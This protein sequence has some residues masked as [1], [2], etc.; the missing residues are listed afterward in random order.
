M[1]LPALLLA[2]AALAACGETRDVANQFEET[3]KE[4]ANTANSI[5]STADNAARAAESALDE[6]AREWQ[7]KSL[8]V[9]V[10]VE[11]RQ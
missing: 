11:N 8:E 9:N 1:K 5:E 4:I 3:G 2:T 7:N 10:T 6:N